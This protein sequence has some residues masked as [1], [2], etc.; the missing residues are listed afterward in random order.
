[1][2]VIEF[3]AILKPDG[4]IDVPAEYIPKLSGSVRAVLFL[5]NVYDGEAVD[6]RQIPDFDEVSISTKNFRFN[7]EEA[8][9]R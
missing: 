9:E 5:D 6:D 8:N 7:R 4:S 2:S 3:R 1:M